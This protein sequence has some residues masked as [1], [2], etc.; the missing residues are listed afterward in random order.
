[1]TVEDGAGPE[2]RRLVTERLPA[3]VPAETWKVPVL[4]AAPKPFEVGGRPV[5]V[6]GLEGD[7][8]LPRRD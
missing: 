1:M 7:L 2:E 3:P 8:D 5:T 4:P 6:T